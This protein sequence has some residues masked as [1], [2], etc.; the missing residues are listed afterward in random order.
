MQLPPCPITGL[1]PLRRIHGMSKSLIRDIWRFYQGVDVEALFSEVERFN[2]YESPT[3]LVY[4]D[5]P[6]I[7]D[8]AFYESYY[9][10]WDVHK[11]L[12]YKSDLR[13]DYT[14]TASFA[15]DGASVIDVGCGPGAFRA[16]ATALDMEVVEAGA[17]PPSFHQG[18]IYW[19]HRLLTRRTSRSPNERHYSHR[20][21]WHLSILIAYALSKVACRIRPLPLNA[22]PL[23]A[24]LVARKR[25][26]RQAPGS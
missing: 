10:K 13:A 4:F 21:S 20:W 24:Y 12:R 17:L 15:P 3:G 8:H 23:D 1:P 6:I 14:R 19:L 2:L 16:L 5:P 26:S 11:G 18:Q 25:Q 9:K 22:Q 7:G